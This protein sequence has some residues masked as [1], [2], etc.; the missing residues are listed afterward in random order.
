VTIGIVYRLYCPKG[1]G[2]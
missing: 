1:L 2:F